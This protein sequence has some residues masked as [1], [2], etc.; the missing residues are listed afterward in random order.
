LIQT[1]RFVLQYEPCNLVELCQQVLDEFTCGTSPQPEVSSGEEDRLEI[2]ADI[3]QRRMS[4]VLLNLLSNARKYSAKNTP[5]TLILSYQQHEASIAVQDRGVGIPPEAL[6]HIYEQFYRVPGIDVQQSGSSPGLGLGLYI[7]KAIVT[8][9]G[10]H[11]TVESTPGQG[12]IFTIAL[13]AHARP[14]SFA[15]ET[16]TDTPLFQ[17]AW[18]FT[19]A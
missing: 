15:R 6:S 18:T 19:P 13:P 17:V 10:G 11:I 8:Q 12:S 9:H 16:D 5:I 3:D 2:I 7:A 14:A 1:G 4:Q